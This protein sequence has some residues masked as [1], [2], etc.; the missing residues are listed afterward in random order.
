M[1]RVCIVHTRTYSIVC[2]LMFLCQ[3][4]QI[5]G[6][7][8]ICPFRPNSAKKLFARDNL[9]NLL[10][11]SIFFLIKVCSGMYCTAVGYVGSIQYT[12]QYEQYHIGTYRTYKV[13]IPCRE[14][15]GGS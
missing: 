10:G 7:A 2:I 4:V 9:E 14:R 11:L 6:S 15:E 1:Y 12:V 5:A 13:S 8:K 3:S